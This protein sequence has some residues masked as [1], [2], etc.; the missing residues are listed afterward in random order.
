MID[1]MWEVRE[2]DSTSG[3]GNQ[4]VALSILR[5]EALR[6]TKFILQIRKSKPE[7]L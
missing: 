4:C 1:G 3:L 7:A 2:G 6:R 5:E